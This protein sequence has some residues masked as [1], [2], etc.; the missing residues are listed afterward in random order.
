MYETALDSGVSFKER[1]L[2]ETIIAVQ[3]LQYAYAHKHEHK[4]AL[5]L[6]DI[7]FTARA[8][9]RIGLIGANGVGTGEAGGLG[10]KAD[11]PPERR[12]EEAGGHSR[13]SDAHAA[14]SAHG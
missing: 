11:L 4:E 5:V 14:A 9:E 7:S 6:K 3:H 10:E 8:G 13:D 12:A 2:E 1:I